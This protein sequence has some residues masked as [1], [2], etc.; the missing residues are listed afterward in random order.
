MDGWM[1]INLFI[2]GI[3]KTELNIKWSIFLQLYTDGL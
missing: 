1:D 2:S 3:D